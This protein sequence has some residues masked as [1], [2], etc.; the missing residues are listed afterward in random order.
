MCP[1]GNVHLKNKTFSYAVDGERK[2]YATFVQRLQCPQCGNW[3]S[4]PG[5]SFHPEDIP[6]GKSDTDETGVRF[7][8]GGGA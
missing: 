4:R 3:V 2:I 8:R 5:L 6:L 1:C 7:G